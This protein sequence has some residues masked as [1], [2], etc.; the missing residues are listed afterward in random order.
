MTTTAKRITIHSTQGRD[1][2]V[3]GG[4]FTMECQRDTTRMRDAQLM[5]TS[6]ELL[7]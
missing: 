2:Q 6:E 3:P 5:G 7:S 1:I 4:T